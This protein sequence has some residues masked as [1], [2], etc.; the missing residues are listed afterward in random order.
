MERGGR[1]QCLSRVEWWLKQYLPEKKIFLYK[2][3]CCFY[4]TPP[5]GVIS[6]K[7]NFRIICAPKS[8]IPYMA[9]YI[10]S[11]LFPI[12]RMCLYQPMSTSK[13]VW[14]VSSEQGIVGILREPQRCRG[15]VSFKR[16]CTSEREDYH[17]GKDFEVQYF[18][19]ILNNSG[20]PLL[21]GWF[22]R[23]IA[24]RN[25]Y[26]KYWCQNSRIVYSQRS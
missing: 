4:I 16:A 19:F 21:R 17:C 25:L 9:T 23:I 12:N 5:L 14:K 1:G 26:P 8:N 22:W 11:E 3:K 2:Q 10:S 24:Y 6:W 15:E 7:N 20:C 18:E 13:A